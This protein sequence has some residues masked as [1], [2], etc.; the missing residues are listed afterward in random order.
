MDSLSRFLLQ[1]F[2]NFDCNLDRSDLSIDFIKELTKFSLPAAAVNTSNNIPPICLE[3]VLSLIENIYNDVQRF[4]RAEFVKNQKEI[5]ILKQ[6]DR[7]TEFI[8]CVE[9]FNEKAKKG[10]QMLIE[11]GFIDSDSN[12]D[13]ASFLFLNNGRLNK[14]TIGLLLCDPKNFIVKRIYR[15][16]RF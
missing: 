9:T 12:R 2:V 14:K 15:S 11:K 13:I 4:D 7:K 8:L 1:L 6:R 5:D 10:I 16:I 3:G